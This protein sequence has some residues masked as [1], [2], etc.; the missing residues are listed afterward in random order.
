MKLTQKFLQKIINEIE[1]GRGLDPIE[2][3]KHSNGHIVLYAKSDKEYTYC[4]SSKLKVPQD[5]SGE[6]II[7]EFKPKKEISSDNAIDIIRQGTV[8]KMKS[9]IL[10]K[11]SGGGD[12]SY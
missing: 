11:N 3:I 4:Y 2:A 5:F 10:S 9:N 7:F 6:M 8:E 1:E 12:N